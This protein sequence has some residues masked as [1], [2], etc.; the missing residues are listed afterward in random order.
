MQ[1]VSRQGV[2]AILLLLLGGAAISISLKA[3]CQLVDDGSTNILDGVSTNL[4]VPV[5]VG[6]NAPFTMLVLTNG[7]TVTN[8]FGSL[9][10]GYN[11]G[12]N[13]NSVIMGGPGTVW[14]NF[15]SR[16]GYNG[17][18][19][20]LSI[21]DGAVVAGRDL[22]LAENF[23]AN[24]NLAVISG[25]GSLCTNSDLTYIAS[26]SRNQLI[27][28]NGGTVAGRIAYVYGN[29][30]S[31][32]VTGTNSTWKCG[33]L[34]VGRFGAGLASYDQVLVNNGGAVSN[35]AACTVGWLSQ[36][37]FI[38]VAD[39]G[40]SF[41]SGSIVLGHASGGNQLVV[42]NG[43][44]VS[45]NYT[46]VED[47][48]GS[49]SQVIITGSGSLLTN[50]TDF[51]LGQAGVSNLLVVTDGG[52]LADSFGYIGNFNLA[53]SGN[54]AII[55]GPHSSWANRSDFYAGFGSP[56]NQLI[57][58]NGAKL[59]D[60][61]G[62]IGY[63]SHSNT[64]IVTGADSLW[65]NRLNFYV[66]NGT[67]NNQLFITNGGTVIGVNSYF[68]G[69]SSGVSNTAVVGDPGSLWKTLQTLSI[70]STS[71][72]ANQLVVS[73]SGTVLASTLTVN[74]GPF[75]F[76]MLIS[77]GNLIVTNSILLLGSGPG[78]FTL[79][80]GL[81][82][83]DYLSSSQTTFDFRAGTLQLHS[84][85]I[86]GTSPFNIGNG[87]AQATLE[88]HNYGSH[89]FTSHNLVVSSNATLKGVGTIMANVTISNGATISPSPSWGSSVG[90]MI[91]G[92]DLL[93]GPGS[94]NLMGLN[95]SGNFAKFDYFV[96]I[97]NMTYGGTLLL[98]NITGQLAA[99]NS[100]QLFSASNYSGAFS[101]ILPLS[102]GPGLKWNT[103]ELNVDGVLRVVAL[104]PLPPTIAAQL[105]GTNFQVRA[106]GGIPYDPCYLLTTTNLASPAAWETCGTNIFDPFGNT[107]FNPTIFLDE[108]ERFFRLQVQ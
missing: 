95:G 66:G 45:A 96:G 75:G 36:S 91:I 15:A 4:N 29:S 64:V 103:N 21:L 49:N 3:R 46:Y 56:R 23:S 61:S 60:A 22:G 13:S 102:P 67:G 104:Q 72:S 58:S 24:N 8:I 37:N 88:L 69:A 81:V 28:T 47:N 11:A 83:A 82:A 48:S 33:S 63:G 44:V 89:N 42:S 51:R 14:T 74:V 62:Y 99:G 43:G 73:N 52:T 98:T 86:V 50:Q 80:S 9:N 10:I 25:A 101:A 94:T 90:S 7:A 35:A 78:F 26:G 57:I 1:S 40:S 105:S 65:T 84:S 55:D 41:R 19:N 54:L 5:Y 39:P 12:A 16:V 32:T 97:S 71:G 34:D 108:K 77:G 106:S 107:I 76:K 18:Y 70:G 38:F 85:Q 2:R 31:V 30:N 27:I 100:F 92:G 6:S 87:V 93:L 20:R 59:F 53:G 17:S 68:G 79:D